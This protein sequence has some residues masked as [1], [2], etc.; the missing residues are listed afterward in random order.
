[1]FDTIGQAH[2]SELHFKSDESAHLQA[3]IAIHN[4]KLGP[5]LGGCRCIEYASDD[6][7]IT[8]A[9]RLARGMSYKAALAKVPQGG[10]KAVILKPKQDYDRAALFRA[11]GKFVNELGGRYITAVD[12]GSSLNDMDA[13]A[14][15]TP[16]V[17][18]S[19]IDGLDPSPM[20]ALGVLAGM[21]AAAFHR[22]G[23]A[24]LAGR[25]VA[26]QGV[27]N[28]GFALAELLHKEGARLLVSDI[29][30]HK[31]EQVRRAF[32]AEA[33]TP[34]NF[35]HVH[36]HILAPCGL[37]A[38]LNDATL[39]QLDCDIIAGSAN[40]QLADARH[41][42]ILHERGVLYVPDYVINAG[43]LIKVSL[44][45]LQRSESAIRTKTWGIGET[46]L[47]IFDRATAENLPS[48]QVADQ[49]AEEILYH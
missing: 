43:G 18:G 34:E 22:Y 27:G 37:G 15:L 41:G 36:C 12:S 16:Y 9:I 11:F 26:I 47:H 32:G 7:A 23:N 8:D 38:I 4:T 3:I 13:V 39:E 10:G 19:N 45:H 28:V 42:Q 1:M 25:I 35:F 17:S 5:A 30:P 20:T 14:R 21:K 49:M 33:V 31:V 2:L 48:S 6:A 29:D 44:G 46:L 24:D 40:N